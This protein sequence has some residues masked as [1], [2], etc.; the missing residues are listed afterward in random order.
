MTYRADSHDE[1]PMRRMLRSIG[2]CSD[3]GVEQVRKT[4]HGLRPPTQTEAERIVAEQMAPRA[5]HADPSAE[6]RR[7]LRAIASGGVAGQ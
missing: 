7:I 2:E 5:E 1:S 3:R 6:T 4:L